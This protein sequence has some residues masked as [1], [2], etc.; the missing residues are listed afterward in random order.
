MHET[1]RIG[2][3]EGLLTLDELQEVRIQ[4][5]KMMADRRTEF[6][7]ALR[8]RSV[9]RIAGESVL[10][11]K[12]VYEPQGRIE[13]DELPGEIADLAK[14]AVERRM[15]DIRPTFPGAC[16]SMDW[17][18]VEYSAGQFIT[19]HVDYPN[20]EADSARPKVA[21][22]SLLV[23][24]PDEGGEFFVETFANHYMWSQAGALRRGADYHSDTFRRMPKTRWRSSIRAGD[25]VLSGTEMVHGTEP[26]IRGVASKLIGFLGT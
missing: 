9:H 5:Q 18:Y 7:V 12:E 23:D 16:K 2:S 17:F 3:V 6:E 10:R 13:Y 4:I 22:I 1:L 14:S 11:A 24:S 25:A 19:P 26:V 20:N 21:A 8:R 15:E